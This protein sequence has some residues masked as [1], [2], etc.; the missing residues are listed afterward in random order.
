M[1]TRTVPGGYRSFPARRS[2]SYALA[3]VAAAGGCLGWSSGARGD[4]PQAPKGADGQSAEFFGP[5]LINVSLDLSGRKGVNGIDG[6]YYPQDNGPTLYSAQIGGDGG[7]G[8]D[9]TLHGGGIIN[10]DGTEA[11]LVRGGD[12]GSGGVAAYGIPYIP[13]PPWIPPY[14]NETLPDGYQGNGGNV[15]LNAPT[16]MTLSGSAKIDGTGLIGGTFNATG[17][18]ATL[19]GTSSIT[20]FRAVNLRGG[21]SVLITEGAEINHQSPRDYSSTGYALS[22]QENSTLR[23]TGGK[24]MAPRPSLTDSTLRVEG[25]QF[26][27]SGTNAM[28]M[29]LNHSTFIQ[30]AG[31]VT[32]AGLDA[33]GGSTWTMSGGTVQSR[34]A[35]LN[36]TTF[37]MTGGAL[38]GIQIDAKGGSQI[39]VLAGSMNLGWT[40]TYTPVSLTDSTMRIGTTTT[41]PTLT[42][43]PPEGLAIHLVRSTLTIEGGAL[44]LNGDIRIE[45]HSTLRVNAARFNGGVGSAVGLDW[46]DGVV[47]I[48]DNSFNLG[49]TT[50]LG[51]MLGGN[52][53][54]VD[55]GKTL[56]ADHALG[57][58]SVDLNVKDG[59]QFSAGQL[60]GLGT[61]SGASA[62]AV[63]VSTSTGTTV[64]MNADTVTGVRTAGST[65]PALV[66][67]DFDL[68]G[69]QLTFFAQEGASTPRTTLQVTGSASDGTVVVSQGLNSRSSVQFIVFNSS[70]ALTV[71]GPGAQV[72]A[73]LA[74]ATFAGLQ[75]SGGVLLEGANR[76]NTTSLRLYSGVLSGPGTLELTGAGEQYFNGA[77]TRTG[78]TFIR[79]GTTTLGAQGGLGTG[80]ITLDGGTLK[81][82][83]TQ[84][85]ANALNLSP[86]GGTIHTGGVTFTST[87]AINPTTGSGGPLTITGGGEWVRA[88]AAT[89]AGGTIV[90]GGATARLGTGL[91]VGTGEVTLN[92]GTIKAGAVLVTGRNTLKL[93]TSGGTIDT[94]GSANAVGW[95]FDIASANGSSDGGLNLKGGGQVLLS[96][97]KTYRGGTTIS[98]N[99]FAVVDTGAALGTGEVTLNAGG[100][101]ASQFTVGRAG[102]RLGTSG[103]A[104]DTNGQT[105]FWSHPIS[106]AAGVTSDGGLQVFGSGVL[107]LTGANTYKGNTVLNAGV[108]RLNN[109]VGSATGL[110]SVLVQGG[111]LAGTGHIG[112]N[113]LVSLAM[114]S[115]AIS[116]GNSAGTLS[117]GGLG[118]VGLHGGEIVMELGSQ[119]DLITFSSLSDHLRGFGTTL[120]IVPVAGFSPTER[121]PIFSNV[122]NA[123][124][125]FAFA[126]ITGVDPSLAPSVVYDGALNSYVVTFVP[127]PGATALMMLGGL[128]ACRRRRA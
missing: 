41:T 64:R 78:A 126:A 20:G 30:S 102:I 15:F 127:T 117:I 110:G 95:N 87:G 58:G 109:T 14:P 124:N 39:D 68:A 10:L 122:Q 100:I 94:G 52:T 8:G 86:A 31:E 120:R 84:T 106:A 32:L 53:V 88:S 66:S 112:S 73:R 80:A 35:L 72:T 37:T 108:L 119:S 121:Y 111:T 103:G 99:T 56:I 123:G 26:S 7:T 44:Y 85:L 90:T 125:L 101:R 21:S 60:L 29:D 18:N 75:G 81:A 59:G 89:Y 23:M 33:W 40:S 97:A 27:N 48:L 11:I 13:I 70:A 71:G 113:A 9:L 38:S 49:A 1:R 54:L 62:L 114:S 65:G 105:I 42:F 93:G 82:S 92:N 4:I 76:L 55:A 118:V 45:D 104:F 24:V 50:T 83:V 98:G 17:L 74:D 57:V 67:G 3:L 43:D 36:D 79:A 5:V 16:T 25:G 12:G 128:L 63:G 2:R 116:P 19:S 61:A 34:R 107:E 6:F 77:S 51:Q 69:G 28:G 46:Q 96:G 47:Q 22:L 115:G 91:A